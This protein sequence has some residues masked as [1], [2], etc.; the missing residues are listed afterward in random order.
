MKLEG[1]LS[2]SVSNLTRKT[3]RYI[4]DFDCSVWASFD[5]HTA[6]DAEVFRNLADS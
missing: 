3:L 4:N 6:T 1:V 2:I 5:A